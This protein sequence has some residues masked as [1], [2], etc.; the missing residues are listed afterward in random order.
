MSNGYS[1]LSSL[2]Q[3]VKNQANMDIIE[4]LLQAIRD[5]PKLL[6]VFKELVENDP[7][8]LDMAEKRQEKLDKQ[9]E[10]E[11][12]YRHMEKRSIKANQFWEQEG[13]KGEWKNNE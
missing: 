11:Q 7:V 3:P 10:M 5:D 12:Y 13:T 6:K 8:I 9:E 1:T 4:S 2:P